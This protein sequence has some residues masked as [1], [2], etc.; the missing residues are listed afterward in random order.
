MA[1]RQELMKK[2]FM[3]VPVIYV[4]DEVVHGFDKAKLEQLLGL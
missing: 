2:G 1:A 3:G 4:E